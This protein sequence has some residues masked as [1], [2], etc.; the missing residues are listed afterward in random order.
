MVMGQFERRIANW[1]GLEGSGMFD[2]TQ[3]VGSC[4]D[5]CPDNKVSMFDGQCSSAK[6]NH[7]K[8]RFPAN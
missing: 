4:G 6:S 2:T 7:F 5:N 3:E 8:A 1:S